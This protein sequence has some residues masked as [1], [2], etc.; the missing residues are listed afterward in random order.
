MAYIPTFENVFV[1]SGIIETSY[2]FYHLLFRR[3]SASVSKKINSLN[4]VPSTVVFVNDFEKSF[5]FSYIFSVKFLKTSI[6]FKKFLGYVIFF[7]L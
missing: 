6:I 3:S 4:L 5:S 7:M 1:A 2:V